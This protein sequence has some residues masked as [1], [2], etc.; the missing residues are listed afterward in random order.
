M[1]AER[2]DENVRP[3][4]FEDRGAFAAPIVPPPQTS[5]EPAA[6]RL[7]RLSQF[8]PGHVFWL[9]RGATWLNTDKPR[10]FVL[11]TNCG[12]GTLG[13]LIYG[14]TRDTEAHFGAPCVHVDLAPA[15]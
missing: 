5:Y 15:A 4:P 6:A 13:T 10:P 1:D 2:P 3:S 11:A 7:I 12:I 8:Q 9:A 14:S